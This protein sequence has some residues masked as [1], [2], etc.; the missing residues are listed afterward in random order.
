M[1]DQ[2]LPVW[3][4]WKSL[5][6]DGS[7]KFSRGNIYMQIIESV[8]WLLTH[9]M[10][11]GANS[12]MYVNIQA[13]CRNKREYTKGKMWKYTHMHTAEVMR[14]CMRA[15]KPLFR[16]SFTSLSTGLSVC[17]YM[18][19]F[20]CF[21]VSLDVR[22]D[23]HTQSWCIWLYQIKNKQNGSMEAAF[24]GSELWLKSKIYWR[25]KTDFFSMFSFRFRFFFLSPGCWI[26]RENDLRI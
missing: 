8:C 3:G 11:K 1:L 9:E 18:C 14:W 16:A 12:C 21:P 7:C 6:M 23:K 4:Q 17:L 22:S 15:L 19:V 20:V 25:K 13:T 5:V 10:H 2:R 26:C 24:D